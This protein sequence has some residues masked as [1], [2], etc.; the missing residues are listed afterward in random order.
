MHLIIDEI[1]DYIKLKNLKLRRL[2]NRK[3]TKNKRARCNI[4]LIIL[5]L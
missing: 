2:I 4:G 1:V 3:L 5:I